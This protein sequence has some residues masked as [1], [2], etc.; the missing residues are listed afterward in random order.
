MATVRFFAQA[1]DAAGCRTATIEGETVAEV[2]EAASERFG[3]HLAQVIEISAIWCNGEFAPPDQRV[4]DS[5]E[6]AV[7]PPVSGG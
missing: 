5:D 3:S 7:L 2:L 1:K 6:V 4:G